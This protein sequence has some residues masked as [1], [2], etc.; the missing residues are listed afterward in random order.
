MSAPTDKRIK[1]GRDEAGR[2]L[3]GVMPAA[4]AERFGFSPVDRPPP[5]LVRRGGRLENNPCYRLPPRPRPM[6]ARRS[7]LQPSPSPSPSSSS[8]DSEA[9]SSDSDEHVTPLRGRPYPM[10]APHPSFLHTYLEESRR[11]YIADSQPQQPQQQLQ[12]QAD[13]DATTVC[14]DAVSSPPVKGEAVD[15]GG[16]GM[17]S[18]TA[19][20]ASRNNGI[21]ARQSPAAFRIAYPHGRCPGLAC[22]GVCGGA[23]RPEKS[24]RCHCPS[25][26][27]GQLPRLCVHCKANAAIR[28]RAVQRLERV[29]QRHHDQAIAA[30]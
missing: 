18:S 26:N 27:E 17:G 8:S 23:C 2:L 11:S 10:A 15:A 21:S 6:L 16:N 1:L 4:V 25:S 19:T 24:V 20:H 7:D 22:H 14:E 29:Q 13:D 28:D 9:S 3:P 5:M 12:P 30:E